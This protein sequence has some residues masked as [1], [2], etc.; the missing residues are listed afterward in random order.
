MEVHTAF[1]KRIL[2][3]KRNTSNAMIYIET[4]RVP[5]ITRRKF[6][7]VKYWLKLTKFENCILKSIDETELEASMGNRT[8]KLI[9]EIQ[10]ILHSTGMSGGVSLFQMKELFYSV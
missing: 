8:N 7:M 2:G 10:N 3:V 6:N 1:M 4:G 9:N 5:L